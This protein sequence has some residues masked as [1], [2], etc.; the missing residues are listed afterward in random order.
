MLKITAKAIEKKKT[1][2]LAELWFDSQITFIQP[3]EMLPQP[4][5]S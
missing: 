1:K 5:P 3:L 2:K 4:A